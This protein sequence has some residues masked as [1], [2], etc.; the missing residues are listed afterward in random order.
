MKRIILDT[1]TIITLS[2]NCLMWILKELR[3]K[4]GIDFAITNSVKKELVD[5]PINSKRWRLDALRVAKRISEGTIT[6]IDSNEIREKGE[7]LCFIANNVFRAYGRNI[8]IMHTGECEVISAALLTGSYAI[9]TDEKTTR[10]LIENPNKL[11]NLL[12]S[13]LH[14]K[15][16]TDKA[17][18][19]KIKQEISK[20]EVLRSAEIVAYAYTKNIFDYFKGSDKKTLVSGL[21][22]ALRLAGCS[23]SNDEID[24]Y[25]KL[26]ERRNEA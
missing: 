25:V 20:I 26:L 18:L 15:I 2:S 3:Q 9:A 24:D 7:K 6:L 10:L 11:E 13:K 23:I 4:Q 17:M 14:T 22:W 21:I 12:S 8:S 5:N 1:S 16:K 19:K